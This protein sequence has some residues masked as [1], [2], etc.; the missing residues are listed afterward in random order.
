M[1][2]G[3]FSSANTASVIG[4]GDVGV[5]D[6]VCTEGA[7]SGSHCNIKVTAETVSTCDALGCFDTIEATQQSSNN[8]AAENGDSGGPVITLRHTSSGQVRASGMIQ[9][10]S[11][12]PS[13]CASYAA[14]IPTTC[15]DTV[16][17]TS[18][19]TIVKYTP[20]LTLDTVNGL[21][22]G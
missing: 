11:G 4:F 16:Y 1:F 21:I 2:S 5:N 7:N 8:I 14:Y 19:R 9:A 18:A 20:G 10:G 6:L 22:S 15:Y 12:T 13:N 3:N 17:F